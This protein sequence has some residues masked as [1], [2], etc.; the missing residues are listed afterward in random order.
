MK[1]QLREMTRAIGFA[2]EMGGWV[3][4]LPEAADL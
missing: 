1:I 2:S 3:S 4:G